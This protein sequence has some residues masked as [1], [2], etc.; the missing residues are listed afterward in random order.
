MRMLMIGLQLIIEL[1]T[2]QAIMVLVSMSTQPPRFL[3]SLVH[4]KHD[5][6]NA[7]TNKTKRKTQNKNLET[8]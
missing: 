8:D 1:E 3:F 6:K 2:I 7:H 4:C 5:F